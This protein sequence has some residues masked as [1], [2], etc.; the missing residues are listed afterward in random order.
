MKINFCKKCLFPETKPD[1]FFD[2]N[3]ICSACNSAQEKY[4]G[5]DWDQ[6]KFE[7]EKI[8]NN[9]RKEGAGYDCIIPVSG[10]KDSTYQP[11]YERG[12]WDE[13]SLHMF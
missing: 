8:I 9:Y 6:R 7:F 13:P 1:L 3:G 12:L 11:F 2:E 10:G 4:N 5:I